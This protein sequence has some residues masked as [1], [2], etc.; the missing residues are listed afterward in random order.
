MKIHARWLGIVLVVLMLL[1]PLAALQAQ[2]GGEITLVPFTNDTFGIQGVVPEGWREAG[3]GIYA[4]GGSGVDLATLIVQAAPGMTADALGTVL[5]GQLGVGSLPEDPA[6]VET[7]AFTWAVYH[8]DFAQGGLS[9]KIDVALAE[10]GGTAYVILLQSSVD[11]YE[12]L[13]AG[14]FTPVLEALAP[15]TAEPTALP[16]ETAEPAPYTAEDV[17]FDNT[18]DASGET[19]TLAG[20]LTIPAGDGPFPAVILISGSGSQDRDESLAPI[21]SFKP[22]AQIADG[23]SRDGIAVLRYDDRGVGGSG[24]DPT[25][26]TSADLSTDA[27][28]A[29]DYLLTRSEIDPAAIGLLGHSEGGIIAPMIAV[30]RSDVAFIVSLAGSVVDGGQLLIKQNERLLEA[31]GATQEE[32]DQQVAFTEDLIALTAAED[33]DG[34]E[35]LF[36]QRVTEQIESLPEDQR[37]SIGDVDAY[38]AQ[39][40]AQQLPAFQ[41]WYAFFFA[42]NPAEDWA[43][44][45]VPALALFGDKDLQ[46]DADQNATALQAIVDEAG[47]EDV[48]IVRFP[49][50]NH[51]FQDAVTGNVDEYATLDQTFIPDLLPTITD[52][53]HARFG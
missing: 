10:A 19:I 4:R 3:P 52:W 38:A 34:L 21:S 42:Y 41:H 24:G 44:V 29:L 45:T 16:D 31:S 12:T 22:F 40:A 50:A 36:V 49:T 14:V 2:G 37:A 35:A 48:T 32:I 13:A 23:L 20:T 9:L 53:I 18:T 51:L 47:L 8:I 1:P 11:E 7:D 17:T 28:A 33:W 5:A 15:Y 46:V 39:Y 6:T 26:A 25:N 27:E 43:K 30:R